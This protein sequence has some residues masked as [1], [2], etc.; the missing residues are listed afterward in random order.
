MLRLVGLE[1]PAPAPFRALAR[2]AR[3]P[4]GADVL[5]HDEW[6]VRPGE[7][8][9]R[10]RDLVRP[11]RGAVALFLALLVRCTVADDGL[12]ADQRRLALL[13]LRAADRPR[14]RLRV[15]AVDA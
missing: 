13:A 14:H 8:L 1:A 11:E 3:V 5:R 7:R 9:A 6:L 4:G 15:M 10:K 2:G 12:A